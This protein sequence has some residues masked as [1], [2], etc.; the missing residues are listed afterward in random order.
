M[1]QYT[2]V[3]HSGYAAG[4][5]RDFEDAVQVCELNAHQVYL[6]RAS[7]GALFATQEAAQRAASSN[8]YPN[9]ATHAPPNVSGYFSSL[10]IG[11]AEIY[12]PSATQGSSG[13]AS[14]T[15]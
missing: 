13:A 4:G 1:S 12:V 2:L 8:N 5:N 3:R 9:G 6:V 7:G 15:V 14:A 10:R 11:G